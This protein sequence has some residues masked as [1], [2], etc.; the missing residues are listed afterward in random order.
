MGLRNDRP[1]VWS[2]KEEGS[3]KIEF[4]GIDLKKEKRR[5]KVRVNSM[6]GFVYSQVIYKREHFDDANA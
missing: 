2:I 3:A 6:G 1:N 5:R 4:F